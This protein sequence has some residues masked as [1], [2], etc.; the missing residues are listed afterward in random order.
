[1]SKILTK[2][3][4]ASKKIVRSVFMGTPNLI[5]TSDLNRQFEAIKYQM[6]Q[7]DEKTGFL[8]DCSITQ[9]LSGSTL[10]VNFSYEYMKFK[11]CSFSPEK[12]ALTINLTKSAPIVYVCLLATVETVD[13]SSDSTHLI[14]G[15]KFEDG[16]SQ[17]AANQLVYKNEEFFLTHGLSGVE[18]LV[19]VLAVIELKDS[20]NVI[21]KSNCID[22]KTSLRMD[23]S[24]SIKD[25]SKDLTDLNIKIGDTYDE[26]FSKVKEVLNNTNYTESDLWQSANVGDE[27][28][29]FSYKMADGL[30]MLKNNEVTLSAAGASSLILGTLNLGEKYS[31]WIRQKFGESGQFRI[32][33]AYFYKSDSTGGVNA[34]IGV[35][36]Q[37]TEGEGAV[38]MGIGESGIQ[39]TS[40]NVKSVVGNT[41]IVKLMDSGSI[42][43]PAQRY[44]IPVK[45]D[46]QLS[47]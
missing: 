2:V 24:G 27:V 36:L 29:P 3:F 17:P 33:S 18:N 47:L 7:L 46:L 43:I 37:V 41:E 21:V 4:D 9:S 16:S 10:T 19:G 45:P 28:K 42:Y 44:I 20:R 15:A 26:A 40:S 39:W 30:L 22:E 35:Y 31:S 25:F 13:Y 32:A 6:D 11:G 12:K 8:S 14:A 5:T 34:Q 1:M 38:L 23:N